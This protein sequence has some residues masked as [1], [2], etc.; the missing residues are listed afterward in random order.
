MV[1]SFRG[2]FVIHIKIQLSWYAR[3]RWSVQYERILNAQVMRKYSEKNIQC[4][5]HTYINTIIITIYNLN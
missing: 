3:A 5:I 2:N 4:T 1:V